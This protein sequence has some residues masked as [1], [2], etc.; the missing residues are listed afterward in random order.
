[1]LYGRY[2]RRILGLAIRSGPIVVG[3]QSCAKSWPSSTTTA[4]T[5]PAL[6]IACCAASPRPKSSRKCCALPI[7]TSKRF[8]AQPLSILTHSKIC[9][10]ST[11]TKTSRLKATETL[12]QCGNAACM[13]EAVDGPGDRDTALPHRD[14]DHRCY[15]W[16]RAT[17]IA[18]L[19]GKRVDGQ[20]SEPGCDC[21]SDAHSRSNV[22]WGCIADIKPKH[23]SSHIRFPSVRI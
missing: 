23:G 11:N 19:P 17:E 21:N 6:A 18:V 8:L 5:S 15:C 10:R 4:A 1:M 16:P 2:H 13:R 3:K 20:V 14:G 9:A 22:V 7:P 12:N